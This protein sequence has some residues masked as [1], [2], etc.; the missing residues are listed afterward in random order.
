MI[1]LAIILGLLGLWLWRRSNALRASTG[2]PWRA[3]VYH[4][5]TRRELSKPL[6]S[7]RYQLTGKPDYV[8]A[9]GKALIPVEVKPQRQATSPR[10]GDILQLAAYCLL[11]EE[12]TGVAPR[13]GL[14]R[15]AQHTFQVDWTDQLYQALIETLETMRADLTLTEVDRSHEEPWRCNACG[16]GDR[17]TD[18]LE[19][20]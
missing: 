2:L 12:A 10:Q 17:C 13:Y 14:L 5:T 3:V 11:L 20:D 6:F 15:Y 8:L 7:A 19:Y 16:F 9:D 4:D 1:W 18:A